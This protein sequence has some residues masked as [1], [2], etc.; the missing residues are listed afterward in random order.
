MAGEPLGRLHVEV[1]PGCLFDQGI[2]WMLISPYCRKS[3]P[4]G[5]ETILLLA[6]TVALPKHTCTRMF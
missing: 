6:V 1:I 4:T 2:R 5:G 3:F